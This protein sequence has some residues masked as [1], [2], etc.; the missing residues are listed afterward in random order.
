[1][2]IAS[3]RVASTRTGVPYRTIETPYCCAAPKLS[4]EQEPMIGQTLI[5]MRKPAWQGT[6]YVCIALVSNKK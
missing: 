3:I 5:D 4:V 6:G 2:S 1:M